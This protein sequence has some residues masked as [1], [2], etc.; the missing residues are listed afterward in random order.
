VL[1]NFYNLVKS[2]WSQ[3]SIAIASFS[4][5]RRLPWKPFL[6]LYLLCF[7][8]CLSRQNSCMLP[9]F[10]ANRDSWHRQPWY[11]N[12]HTI[13]KLFVWKSRGL[14][15]VEA[16]G[17]C[18]GWLFVCS[19]RSRNVFGGCWVDEVCG[20]VQ[21]FGGYGM[22][23]P[24]TPFEQNYRCYSASFIDKVSSI[25]LISTMDCLFGFY[26]GF[27]ALDGVKDGVR[28][29]YECFETEFT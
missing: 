22:P 18:I 1:C 16:A 28:Y 4:L 17:V 7:L 25:V 9:I 24:S 15:V 3:K 27:Q 19:S 10:A 29:W 5:R 20:W 8:L 21:Y 14:V 23:Y 13:A 26:E 11:E 6:A 2:Y 12:A